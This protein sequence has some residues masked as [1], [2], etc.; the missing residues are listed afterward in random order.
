MLEAPSPLPLDIPEPLP[1]INTPPTSA[2]FLKSPFHANLDELYKMAD[3]CFPASWKRDYAT[4]GLD[5]WMLD[6][7]RNFL[8]LEN[9]LKNKLHE[10]YPVIPLPLASI[11]L[12]RKKA[13][14][15][16][17]LVIDPLTFFVPLFVHHDRTPVSM[18]MKH[19]ERLRLQVALTDIKP[20]V[21]HVQRLQETGKK[22]F[23]DAW[24]FPVFPDPGTMLLISQSGTD[25]DMG[26]FDSRKR[27]EYAAVTECIKAHGNSEWIDMYRKM[28]QYAPA[29]LARDTLENSYTKFLP[30]TPCMPEAQWDPVKFFECIKL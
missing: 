23:G 7:H 8:L 6:T 24:E 22:E 21:T 18:L 27:K 28:I 10:K 17:Y 14:T 29:I 3:S 26:V 11:L 12:D 19:N 1:L 16:H 9:H 5:W 20:L 2:A 13:L 15:H 4:G 30:P 25:W